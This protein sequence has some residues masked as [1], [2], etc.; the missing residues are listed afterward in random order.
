M[1]ST[2]TSPTQYGIS[3]AAWNII[4]A[5]GFIA[6]CV[7]GVI[8]GIT[9][10]TATGHWG[11]IALAACMG[12]IGILGIIRHAVFDAEARD[13][14]IV[15]FVS[16]TSD[17]WPWALASLALFILGVALFFVSPPFGR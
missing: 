7:G 11:M 12:V 17:G 14:G 5:I 1:S 2:A 13:R 4:C 10:A 9:V 15:F 3:M 16:F 6:C 8:Y